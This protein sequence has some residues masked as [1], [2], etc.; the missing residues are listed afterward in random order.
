M[1]LDLVE[2][3]HKSGIG[4]KISEEIADPG[5]DNGSGGAFLFVILVLLT[6]ETKDSNRIL[7]NLDASE[8]RSSKVNRRR[9]CAEGQQ[10][11]TDIVW[12]VQRNSRVQQGV[13]K[14]LRRAFHHDISF[15]GLQC[16][17]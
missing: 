17:T 14:L 8:Q 10:K 12:I 5:D 15:F 11:V 16:E 13:D 9:K 6:N 3:V 7:N 1:E 4:F 2:H